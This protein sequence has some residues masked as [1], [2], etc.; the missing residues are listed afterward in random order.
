[1]GLFSLFRGVN[2]DSAFAFIGDLVQWFGR[3]IPRILIIKA[4]HAGVA[5]VRGSNVVKLDTGLHIYWPFWTDVETYP[6]ARQTLN[7]PMQTLITSEKDEI[8]VGGIVVY[9]INDIVK[10]LGQTWDLDD[11]I[12][13]I[14]MACIKT[15][16]VTHKVDDI[17]ANYKQIDVHLVEELQE[18]LSQFGITVINA[19]LSDF[20]TCIVIRNVGQENSIND[21][22][23][24]SVF[25]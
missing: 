17:L 10:A 18:S 19:Y 2:V 20:S 1:M 24:V 11:T 9:E 7:L 14:S 12:R 22:R 15:V 4:T 5:F 16:I 13:D 25:E 6:V 23:G 3:L 21:K 8:I